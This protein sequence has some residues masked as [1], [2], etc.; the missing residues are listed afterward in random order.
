[1]TSDT[2]KLETPFST[3]LIQVQK[4]T[5]SN[6]QSPTSDWE[7]FAGW[8]KFIGTFSETPEAK[9]LL[10]APIGPLL[11]E[12]ISDG[13]GIEDILLWQSKKDIKNDLAKSVKEFQ[14]T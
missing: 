11:L 12:Q 9:Q 8:K 3:P 6:A 13:S 4:R 5:R 1:P 2:Y 14:D 10:N 7:H